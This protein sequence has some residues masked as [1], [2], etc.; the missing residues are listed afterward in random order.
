MKKP[1][2]RLRVTLSYV[3]IIKC[4]SKNFILFFSKKEMKTKIAMSKPLKFCLNKFIS[5]K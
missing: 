4:E 2:S 3:D 5:L 1:A